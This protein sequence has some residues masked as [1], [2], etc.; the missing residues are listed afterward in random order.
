[1]PET[2]GSG[3]SAQAVA[4]AKSDVNPI[5]RPRALYVG[6]GGDVAVRFQG[7]VADT[8]FKNVPSGNVL[9]IAPS[10]VRAATTAADIVALY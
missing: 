4:V 6:T 2:L 8:V 9:P 7:D 5:S 10:F 3:P 1:M